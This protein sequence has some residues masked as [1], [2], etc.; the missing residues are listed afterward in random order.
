MVDHFSTQNKLL[1]V[2]KARLV[3]DR[4]QTGPLVRRNIAGLHC[5]LTRA[6]FSIY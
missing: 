3:E 1:V 6:E 5:Q 4:R 2:K